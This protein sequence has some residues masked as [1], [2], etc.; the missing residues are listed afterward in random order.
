MHV[1][2]TGDSKW[3]LVNPTFDPVA[4]G[5]GSS[6]PELDEPGIEN[7]QMDNLSDEHAHRKTKQKRKCSSVCN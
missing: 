5:I 7:K 4:A 6:H 1:W 2:L 3:F